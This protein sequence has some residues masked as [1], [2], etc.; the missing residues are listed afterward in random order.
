MTATSGLMAG[1]QIFRQGESS[2]L[3]PKG[4]IIMIALVLAGL[5]LT[6]LQELIYF[7]QNRNTRKR[8]GSGQLNIL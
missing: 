7:I 2:E 5:L 6:G 3:Y 4:I 1:T 8:S